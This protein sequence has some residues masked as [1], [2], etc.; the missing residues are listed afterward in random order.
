[1][2]I[3]SCP[4]AA[5]A[6]RWSHTAEGRLHCHSRGRAQQ[7]QEQLGRRRRRH[8]RLQAGCGS[9][10]AGEQRV[11]A[12]VAPAR[13]RVC[14][15]TGR[16]DSSSRS[17]ARILAADSVE[18]RIHRVYARRQHVAVSLVA[19][20]RLCNICAPRTWYVRV[21]VCSHVRRRT[22]T[23]IAHTRAHTSRA[24]RTHPRRAALRPHDAVVAPRP[25]PPT[26]PPPQGPASVPCEGP[27]ARAPAARVRAQT[28]RSA[29]CTTTARQHSG[30]AFSHCDD[31]QA[32]AS[33]PREAPEESPHAQSSNRKPATRRAHARCPLLNACAHEARTRKHFVAVLAAA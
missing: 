2:I 20:S 25:P 13:V 8:T 1:V 23:R 6:A 5:H 26:A 31:A 27:A 14:G 4:A 15:Q 16:R 29:L 21:C 19:G 22:N 11:D 28:P 3:A 33:T 12:V 10:V 9:D 7:R 17:C 30:A 32:R 18:Q 24:A